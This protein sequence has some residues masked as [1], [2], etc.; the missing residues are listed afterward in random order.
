MISKVSTD[1]EKFR[2]IFRWISDTIRY[3]YSNRT[4]K[5]DLVIKKGCAVCAG[6]AYLLKAMCDRAGIE[7]VVVS[8]YAKT[9]PTDIGKQ[10]TETDHAWNAVKLY[11][12]WYLADLTWASGYY[13]RV[14]KKYTKKFNECYFLADPNFFYKK[15]YTAN[16]EMVF[17]NIKLNRKAFVHLP[18]YYNAYEALLIKDLYPIKGDIKLKLKDSLE[19]SFDT[20]RVI[21]SVHLKFKRKKTYFEPTLCIEDH[22]Y[23]FRYKFDKVTKDFMT[24]YIN[25]EAT[26]AYTI[27]VK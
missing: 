27:W 2:V 6:Y 16:K 1:H 8:G 20:P 18:I 7:C 25:G 11:G 13:D 21:S 9:L 10:L 14:K 17:A 12:K 22:K 5:P 15:H 24:I 19:I 3:S 23:V 4:T 26:V